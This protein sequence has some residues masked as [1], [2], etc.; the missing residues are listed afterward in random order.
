M[1]FVVRN[2]RPE[3]KIADKDIIC[4]KQVRLLYNDNNKNWF[5]YLW[6][7]Y[8]SKFKSTYRSEY[9][10]CEYRLKVRQPKVNLILK[11]SSYQN[12]WCNIDKNGKVSINNNITTLYE[13]HEG[14]HSYKSNRNLIKSERNLVTVVCIIPK[15]TMYYENDICYVSETIVL[16]NRLID[17]NHVFHNQLH[18]TRI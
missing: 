7:L 8:F 11:I 3:R 4:Y 1:C 12:N 6:H 2:E 5:Q 14:Y 13:I 16:N 15:G 10:H 9:D 17:Y 18:K